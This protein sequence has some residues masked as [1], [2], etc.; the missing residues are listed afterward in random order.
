MPSR[1]APARCTSCKAHT[2]CTC[3][4]IKPTPDIHTIQRDYGWA[5]GATKNGGG[6]LR[7][8][9]TLVL[10]AD[11]HCRTAFHP[12]SAS[13]AVCRC[14]CRIYPCLTVECPRESALA[15][16][17]AAATSLCLC[18]LTYASRHIWRAFSALSFASRPWSMALLSSSF[19][20]FSAR[21]RVLEQPARPSVA[22]VPALFE[23]SCARQ[24]PMAATPVFSPDRKQ[25]AESDQRAS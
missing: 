15:A 1:A 7:W 6:E 21:L 11:R 8:G 24:T 2:P 4:R 22:R 10:P 20:H 12:S 23:T 17:T 5:R 14:I 16:L 25:T 9:I 3:A 19:A 13:S 18:R